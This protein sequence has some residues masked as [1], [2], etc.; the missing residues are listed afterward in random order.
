MMSASSV[1]IGDR[2]NDG[3]WSEP[4]AFSLATIGLGV[5]LIALNQNIAGYFLMGAG[6]F[7]FVP[8]YVMAILRRSPRSEDES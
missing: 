7:V 4:T 2:W 5:G 1:N 8:R 3:E 6:L